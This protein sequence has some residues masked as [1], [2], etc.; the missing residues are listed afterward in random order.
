MVGSELPRS[1][2]AAVEEGHCAL[3]KVEGGKEGRKIC[4]LAASVEGAVEEALSLLLIVTHGIGK[5]RVVSYLTGH[6]ERDTDNSSRAG[7]S[8][9]NRGI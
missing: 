7:A 5:L 2:T 6:G 4:Q 3:I 9:L 8:H 1:K